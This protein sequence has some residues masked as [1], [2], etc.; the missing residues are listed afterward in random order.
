M[1]EMNDMMR[2]KHREM[3]ELPSIIDGGSSC[4]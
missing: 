4:L 2:N 3:F 1:N